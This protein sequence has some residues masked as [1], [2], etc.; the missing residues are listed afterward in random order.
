MFDRAAKKL[1]TATLACMVVLPGC[2]RDE[3]PPLAPP[4]SSIQQPQSVPPSSIPPVAP[5]SAPESVATGK[6]VAVATTARPRVLMGEVVPL[7]RLELPAESLAIWREHARQKPTLLLLSSNPMLVPVPEGLREAVQTLLDG[8]SREELARR[9][10]PQTPNPLLTPVMTVD[11]SLRAG[12][13]GRVVWA[14]PLRDPQQELSDKVLR[15]HF[16]ASGMFNGEELRRLEID[17]YLVRG[18][19]RGVS[20]LAAAL[21][22][23]PPL[24]GPLIVHID[25]SYFQDRYKNEVATPLL[26]IVFDT[27]YQLRERRLSVLAVTF[28]YGNLEGRISLPVRYVGEIL[29]HY[30]EHPD[31]V[32]KPVPR[33]W[34][35]Q[36]D[37]FHLEN[38]FEKGKILELAQ[39]MERDDPESSWVRFTLY[40]AMA[41]SN[42][43]DKALARLAE[44]VKHDHMY[45]LE[46]LNLAQL[47]YD[48][49]RPEAALRM[50]QLAA[51]VF[52]D[53]PQIKLR[54]AQLAGGMGDRRSALRLVEQLQ[55]LPWSPVYYPQMPD[56]L[57]GFAEYLR[58]E[59]PSVQP[60]AN[61]TPTPSGHPVGLPPAHLGAMPPGHP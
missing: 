6:P 51:A 4:T 20:L 11:A 12:W 57:K 45:A 30:L 55:Q 35:R 18:T 44:A 7:Q 61:K 47:A 10:S 52:P 5:A 1:L 19:V 39:A 42:Q 54:V 9:G 8:A 38:L 26:Q 41:D 23:L 14:L 17:K 43:G 56:H 15:Q 25:Q 22:N 46:Y 24:Q 21:D 27:L 13:F 16:S 58:T 29:A 34:Q 36:G 50:L 59:P 3:P 37:I 28:T 40:R 48:K 2:G 33:N 31:R 49:K 60:A 32:E 53:N